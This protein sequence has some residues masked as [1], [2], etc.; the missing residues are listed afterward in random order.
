MATVNEKMKAIADAIRD[1]TGETEPLTL[2]DMATDIPK[3]YEAGKKSQYDEFWDNFQDYGNR[4]VYARA[5]MYNWND[6]NFRPKYDMNVTGSLQLTFSYCK[7]TDLAALFERSGV[8]LNTEKATSFSEMIAYS[9]VTRL[10]EIS[11][12]GVTGLSRA[13]ASGNL[14]T[15]DKLILREDGGNEFSN[16]FASCSK[17]ANIVIEGKIGNNISFS[18]SSKLTYDSIMSVINALKDYSGTTITKTL[19][20]HATTKAKLSDS[21][22]AIATQ[23]GWTIA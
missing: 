10:P 20:L 22:I 9:S 7:I 11:V 3:V 16:T 5:F 17:L 6:V 2:D 8:K 23:K 18:D 15:I 4:T 21:D 19:T 1:K 13:F 14:V 12:I